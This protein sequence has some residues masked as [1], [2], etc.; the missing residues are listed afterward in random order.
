ME[1]WW[2]TVHMLLKLSL[3]DRSY[4]QRVGIDKPLKFI[5]KTAAFLQG[6]SKNHLLPLLGMHYIVQD[7]LESISSRT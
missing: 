7:W 3:R 2:V 1:T 6:L 4:G 5:L